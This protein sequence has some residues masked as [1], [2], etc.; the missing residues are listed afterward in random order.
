MPKKA[1]KKSQRKAPT[2]ETTP[3]RRGRLRN[4][5]GDTYEALVGWHYQCVAQL[6]ELGFDATGEA[7]C[8]ALSNYSPEIAK[9][10]EDLGRYRGG[11]VR[12]GTKLKQAFDKAGI[13][14]DLVVRLEKRHWL[15]RSIFQ[16]L[17]P[18]IDQWQRGKRTKED[19][20]EQ[21]QI[22][23]TAHTRDEEEEGELDDPPA[24]TANQARVLVTMNYFDGSRLLLPAT[25]RE[26]MEPR[27]RLS[28]R[29]IRGIVLTL[30][31]LKL[32]E[33]PQGDRQGARL[34]NP[35][36]RLVPKIAD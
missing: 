10:L 19:A 2:K 12:I 16:D 4:D 32:A 25:I 7:P 33:R 18:R 21:Q 13:S 22:P 1:T 11:L 8:L 36:R 29:T 31:E 15:D 9:L 28:E 35:G 23:K 5:I 3:T 26:E 20:D 34:T 6:L 27:Y 30:V 24:L 14:A 17:Q